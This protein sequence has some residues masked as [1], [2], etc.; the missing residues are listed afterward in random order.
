MSKNN[1]RIYTNFIER[2][3]YKLTHTHTYTH[4]HT[5]THIHA[6]KYKKASNKTKDRCLKKK[7][8]RKLR[9]QNIFNVGVLCVRVC[10]CVLIK[11]RPS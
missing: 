10:A 3:W 6:G 4:T 8:D 5:H 9:E 11:C 2:D 7:K 1:E